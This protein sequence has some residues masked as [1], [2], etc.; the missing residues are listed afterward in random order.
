MEVHQFL[1]YWERGFLEYLNGVL[2]LGL[3]SR[4]YCY[5]KTP[6]SQR[7]DD[8]FVPFC[9]VNALVKKNIHN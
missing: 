9:L 8:F 4:I 7:E 6:K 1:I 2:N 3:C 5:G